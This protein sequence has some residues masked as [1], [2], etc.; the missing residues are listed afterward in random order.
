MDITLMRWEFTTSQMIN[1]AV[2][3]AV[4]TNIRNTRLSTKSFETDGRTTTLNII[5]SMERSGMRTIA[6]S[7]Y[8]VPG[9]G[10]LVISTGKQYPIGTVVL[11]RERHWEN[12]LLSRFQR[13]WLIMDTN[14]SIAAVLLRRWIMPFPWTEEDLI[15]PPIWS[16]LV[17]RV[18]A[19][20]I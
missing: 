8:V 18:T 10:P 3:N 19:R 12:Q 14:A 7:I 1:G 17:V 15:I 16:P 4:R 13:E 11:E 2:Y 9:I 5:V 20:N 6:R